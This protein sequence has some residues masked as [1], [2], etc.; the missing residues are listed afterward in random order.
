MSFY[1]ERVLQI[2]TAWF[3]LWAGAGQSGVAAPLQA[4]LESQQSEWVL[5]V[6]VEFTA[7]ISNVSSVP[8]ET[9]GCDLHPYCERM[10]PLIS[11]DGSTFH[12]FLGPEWDLGKRMDLVPG[13]IT[14]KPGT[15][16]Q[17]SF[18]LLWNRPT[19]TTKQA[20]TDGFA[21]PHAGTYSVKI[22][23][24]SGAGDLISN[25]V[26]V[27]I[28]NPEASDA[29]IWE[30]LQADKG[31]ARYYGFPDGAAG[32]GEKLQQLLSTYPNSSHAA[33]MKRALAVYARQKSEVEE[34]KKA[35][36]NPPQQH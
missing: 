6:P 32:Q 28:R 11:E 4:H 9:T 25:V 22:K 26:R 30:V 24:S 8:V 16:V 13:R 31:L 27:V 2:G 18:I 14:L 3:L 19:D 36:S 17:A 29:A 23:V 20:P 1:L 10:I 12:S 21:F 15:K 33:S 34:V 35:R 7:S 5:G